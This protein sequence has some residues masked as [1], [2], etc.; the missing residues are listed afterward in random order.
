MCGLP[1]NYD[2]PLALKALL[3]KRGLGMRKRLGQNFLIKGAIRKK[4]AAA[5]ELRPGDG[6]WEIGPGL[7][8]MTAELLEQG[9]RVKAF[10]I[11][12]GFLEFLQEEFSGNPGFSLVPGDV[13]KTWKGEAEV[14]F[15]LGNLPYNIAAALLGDFAEGNRFFRRMVVTVQKELGCRLTAR[16]GQADYSSFTVLI[17]GLYKIKSLVTM[18][19]SC[20]YPPPRVDS[21]GIRLDLRE[22][23]IPPLTGK[24]THPFPPLMYPMVRRLFSSRRKTVKNSLWAF[25][26]SR[27]GMEQ[28]ARDLTMSA[29]EYCGIRPDERPENLDIPQFRELALQLQRLGLGE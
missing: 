2:S 12:P 23:C 17:A 26:S 27:S 10:E 25:V 1:L 3:E 22:E 21:V 6:V 7:G 9:A 20:F 16:P 4:L 19:A 11:D 8:A 29:L 18:G 28:G 13:L 24:I 15:L 5:L 14:P